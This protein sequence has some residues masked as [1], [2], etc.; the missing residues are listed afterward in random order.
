MVNVYICKKQNMSFVLL[1]FL[2]I[3]YFVMHSAM[4]APQIKQHIL[5]LTGLPE[6]RYRVL[7]NIVAILGILLPLIYHWSLP[8]P[9]LMTEPNVLIEYLGL[10]LMAAAVYLAFKCFQGYSLGEFIGLEQP[11][12]AHKLNTEGLNELVRHP[13]YF[14][15]LV[16]LFGGLLRSPSYVYLV[17]MFWIVLY[18]IIGAQLEEARLVEKFGKAYRDYQDKVPMLI[19]FYKFK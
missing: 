9:T 8:K 10:L 12:S 13:L 5:G 3:C 4:L 19:P 17:T 11:Q 16:F 18:I 14:S 15:A 1:S 2:W 6:N 7:Y